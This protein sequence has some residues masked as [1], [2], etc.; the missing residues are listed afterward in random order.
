MVDAAPIERMLA[1]EDFRSLLF[2]EFDNALER[3][4]LS[5]RGGDDPPVL[6][7][8]TRSKTSRRLC[9]FSVSDSCF[10]T[11]AGKIPRTTAVDGK[12]PEHN[13]MRSRQHSS[14][15]GRSSAARRL[16]AGFW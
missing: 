10:K 11:Y 2:V 15:V 6:V 1:S 16:Q 12:D 14:S 5:D 13:V 4:V 7:P 8:I 9:P 3:N